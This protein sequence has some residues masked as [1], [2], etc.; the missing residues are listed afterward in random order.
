MDGL[1]TKAY[2]TMSHKLCDP[3]DHETDC[4][5]LHRHLGISLVKSVGEM[6]KGEKDG[7]IKELGSKR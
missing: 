6:T 3:T 4:S 2:S 7:G 1:R 5:V